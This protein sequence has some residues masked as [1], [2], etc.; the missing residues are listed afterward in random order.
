MDAF[1]RWSRHQLK[2][3]CKFNINW[4]FP[5][6]LPNMDPI[7]LFSLLLRA[8]TLQPSYDGPINGG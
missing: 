8:L 6:M 5:D 2:L 4:Y 1:S 3:G 7:I